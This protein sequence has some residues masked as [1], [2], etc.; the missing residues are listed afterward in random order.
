MVII[1]A[2]GEVGS[3]LVHLL[4]HEPHEVILVL[5]SPHKPSDCRSLLEVTFKKYIISSG[6]LDMLP[7]VNNRARWRINR[8]VNVVICKCYASTLQAFATR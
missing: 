2:T 1:G 7:G 3:N 4:E 8:R 6:M 5:R